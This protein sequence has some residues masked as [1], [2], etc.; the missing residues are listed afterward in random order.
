[1]SKSIG[2]RVTDSLEDASHDDIRQYLDWLRAAITES[3]SNLRKTV[4]VILLLIA[5]FELV[6]ESPATKISISVF[7]I[8]KGSVVLLFILVIVAYLFFQVVRDTNKFRAIIAAF[9]SA[10]SKWSKK[11]YGNDIEFYVIASMPAYWKPVPD[12]KNKINRSPTSWINRI[13]EGVLG[14]LVLFGSIAFEAQAFY[15]LHRQHGINKLLWAICCFVSASFIIA[16]FAIMQNEDYGF[17]ERDVDYPSTNDGSS[18]SAPGDTDAL[19]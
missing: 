16:A 3:A 11:G 6:I 14:L 4:L 7:Q 5:A 9:S 2:D 18:G 10:F 13:V 19:A 15:L 17:S 8:S 12:A 1:V